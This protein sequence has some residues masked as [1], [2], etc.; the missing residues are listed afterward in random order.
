[1]Q[2][3]L[4]FKPT[5]PLSIPYNYNYQL[6]SALYAMLGEVGE[7]DFWHNN[8]FGNVAK[9]KGFCFGALEGKYSNDREAGKICFDN[10]IYL[11]IRS[12]AFGFIDAIQRSLE[13][14]PY[15]TLFDTQLEVVSA[16][17]ENRH[18]QSGLVQL[19]AVTP[20]VIHSTTDDGYTYYYS[21]EEDEFCERICANIINKYEAV[22]GKKAPDMYIRPTGDFK[23][24]VTKYKG[25]YINGYTG[26]F[27]INTTLKIAEFVYNSGLGE[28]NSQ[29]FG[30]VKTI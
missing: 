17:L 8:G 22:T 27:E 20:V 15:I 11:E 13:L 7:S 24:T 1:M 18:L 25:F 30:F 23:K 16:S 3:K 6:Q 28:K 5:K 29:G 21:P 12:P 26:K 19:N 14:H 9:F 2:I 10:S 4:M